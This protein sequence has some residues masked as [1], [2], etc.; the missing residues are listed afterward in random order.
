M[1]TI[2]LVSLAVSVAFAQFAPQNPQQLQQQPYVQEQQ[3]FRNQPA[4]FSQYSN[5]YNNGYGSTTPSYYGANNNQYGYTTQ[6]YGTN[7]QF[8]QNGQ[9]NGVATTSA[10]MALATTAIAFAL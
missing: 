1:Q 2:L 4:R 10:L 3:F 6:Q 9:F 7:R 5:G 8:D